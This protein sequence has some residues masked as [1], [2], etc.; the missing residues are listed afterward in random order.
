MFIIMNKKTDWKTIV[1][2]Y[3]VAIQPQ[4]KEL[5]EILKKERPEGGYKTLDDIKPET[6]ERLK[7]LKEFCNI[8]DISLLE[9][10]I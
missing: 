1:E 5:Q 7:S 6:L 10:V 9:Q 3:T 8:F 4:I 2:S